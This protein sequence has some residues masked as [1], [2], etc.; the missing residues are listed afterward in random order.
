MD[1]NRIIMQHF[2]ISIRKTRGC[3]SP[4]ICSKNRSR[5]DLGVLFVKLG[6]MIGAEIG[7]RHGHFSKILLNS[8][9]ALKMYCID[10]WKNTRSFSAARHNL[11]NLNAELIRENSMDALSLFKDGSLDF[12][13]IDANHFFDWCTPDIIYWPKKVKS[14]GV[15]ACHDYLRHPRMAVQTAVDGYTYHHNI[16]PWFVTFEALPTAFWVNP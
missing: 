7:V 6:F 5:N 16:N 8:N 2:G 10:S 13:Y 14:G 1:N 3:P 9:P 15:I 11:T 12:V 4:I